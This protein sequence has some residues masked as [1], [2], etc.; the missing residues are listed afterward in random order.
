D[1]LCAG[2]ARR[3]AD[4]RGPLAGERMRDRAAD[5]SRRAGHD[6]DVSG[7]K[8]VARLAHAWLLQASKARCNDSL[9]SIAS[10]SIS[11]FFSMRRFNPVSTLPGPHSTIVRAPLATI[12]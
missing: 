12:A 9:S 11:L 1:V 3:G 7:Q 2:I 6:R 4:D 8:G 5:P 10:I